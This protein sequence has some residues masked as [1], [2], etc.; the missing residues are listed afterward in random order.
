MLNFGALT[1]LTY[2]NSVQLPQ[3]VE[4]VSRRPTSGL[5]IMLYLMGS[6]VANFTYFEWTLNAMRKM[7]IVLEHWWNR[8]LIDAVLVTGGNGA[9]MAVAVVGANTNIDEDAGE[10][11]F[12]SGSMADLL[13][14]LDN[15]DNAWL[16]LQSD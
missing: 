16:F 9:A 10:R 8:P 13:E 7:L 5:L 12:A 2:Q 6:G 1:F 4:A 15:E 3:F 14:A 11:L